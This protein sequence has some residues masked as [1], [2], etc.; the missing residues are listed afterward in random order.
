MLDDAILTGKDMIQIHVCI[1]CRIGPWKLLKG[2]QVKDT[3]V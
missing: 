3:V 1:R 2:T